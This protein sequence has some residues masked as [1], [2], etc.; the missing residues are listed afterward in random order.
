MRSG[1]GSVVVFSA[2]RRATVGGAAAARRAGNHGAP[3]FGGARAGCY[4]PP[5]MFIARKQTKGSHDRGAWPW[6]RWLAPASFAVR[7][8]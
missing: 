6:R 3:R 8:A 7:A 1:V 4:T 2:D 5:T